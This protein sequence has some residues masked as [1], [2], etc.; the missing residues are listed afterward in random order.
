MGGS[1]VSRGLVSGSVVYLSSNYLERDTRTDR[2]DCAC[3]NLSG[4]QN[5]KV[6]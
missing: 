3:L 2:M 5:V 1:I 4:L 6:Y